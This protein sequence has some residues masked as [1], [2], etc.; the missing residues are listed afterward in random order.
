MKRT[1]AQL[2]VIVA[3]VSCPFLAGADEYKI[4]ALEAKLEAFERRLSQIEGKPASAPSQEPVMPQPAAAASNVFT[5][6]QAAKPLETEFSVPQNETYIIRD[7]DTLGG[8]ARKLNVPRNALLRANNLQEGQPIYIGESLVIPKA[9]SPGNAV[10]AADGIVHVVK[11]GD[12]LSGIARRYNASVGD[13]KSAN[14]LHNDTISLGQRLVI[15]K[16]STPAAPP[17]NNNFAYESNPNS[18]SNNELPSSTEPTSGKY[19]YENPLLNPNETYGYYQVKSGDN[20]YALARDFFTT[21]NE[22]QRLNKMGAST[23]IHTG[24]EVVVP[25]SKYNDYHNNIGR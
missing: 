8:I 19:R 23:I 10:P 1:T 13:I 17:A 7:G 25:T 21:P 5:Y 2:L 12:N 11:P 22:L 15:P 20:L 3:S 24:Q 18:S 16:G 6:D 9:S 14:R 4:R